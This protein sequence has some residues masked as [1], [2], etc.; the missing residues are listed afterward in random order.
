MNPFSRLSEDN[1]NQIR[2][3]IRFFRQKKE[4]TIRSLNNEF[5]DAKSDRIKEDMYSREDMEDYTDYVKSAVK[6]SVD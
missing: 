3:Y 1:Q 4:S 5:A 2:K 6:V